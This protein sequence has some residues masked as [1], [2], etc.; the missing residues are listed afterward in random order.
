MVT[1]QVVLT[2]NYDRESLADPEIRRK[3]RGEVT[4]DWY[5][6]S[7]PKHAHGSA[8]LPHHTS[9]S[10]EISEAVLSVYDR[11][12]NP[13]LL[14]RRL[15]VVVNHVLPEEEAKR[16]G[17]GYEQMDLFTDYEALER[18]RKEDEEKRAKERKLQEAMLAVR[19]KFGKDAVIKGL[20]MEEGA[21]GR[22]RNRQIGGHKA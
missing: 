5:G 13:D 22:E 4:K 20:N 7:V 19:K 1:D 10:R 17:A 18:Q 12:V 3:Y 21:T 6:R 11:T 15:T 16:A 14:V 9:S 8:N 2:V